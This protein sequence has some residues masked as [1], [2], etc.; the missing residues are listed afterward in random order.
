MLL[1][2]APRLHRATD[3]LPVDG[4]ALFS[5]SEPTAVLG[6]GIRVLRDK[7]RIALV[8]GRT[9]YKDNLDQRRGVPERR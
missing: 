9:T 2:G 8:R 6:E 7:D 3:S 4:Y 1:G 5:Y